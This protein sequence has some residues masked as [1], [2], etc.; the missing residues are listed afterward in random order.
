MDAIMAKKFPQSFFIPD[1]YPEQ[2]P[3]LTFDSDEDLLDWVRENKGGYEF[4]NFMYTAIQHAVYNSLPMIEI[5]KLITPSVKLSMDIS[6]KNYATA[7]NRLLELSIE[8]EYYELCSE[9]NNLLKI[10]KENK[11]YFE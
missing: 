1:I 6:D 10:L 9:I 8:S 7:L 2:I 11:N 3:I 5:C 4:I